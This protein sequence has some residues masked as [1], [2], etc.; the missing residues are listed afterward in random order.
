MKTCIECGHKNYEGTLICDYCHEPLQKAAIRDTLLINPFQ[1]IPDKPTF[2]LT[3]NVE[4][5]TLMIQTEYGTRLVPFPHGHHF[6]LGRS[7]T[8]FHVIPDIDLSMFGAR[9]LGV[10]R[11]HAAVELTKDT[12]T[13]TDLESRNGTYLNRKQLIPYDINILRSGDEIRLGKLVM[14]ILID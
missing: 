7:D 13:L 9:E 10:S 2:V 3:Q 8:D 14:R 1:G 12:L 4:T 5:L 6:I 11:Q